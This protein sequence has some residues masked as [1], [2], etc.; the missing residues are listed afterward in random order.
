MTDSAATPSTSLQ[1]RNLGLLVATQSLGGASPP[2]I[3]SLGGLVGQMLSSTP[4]AATLPVSLYQLGLALST[5]PAAWLMQRIGRRRAYLL[6]ALL[7]V[8]SGMVAAWGISRSDFVLFCL[9]TSLAGFYGACVQSYRFA[10]IDTVAEPAQHA[11][12][13]SRV[14]VGGLV[15]AV[16]GP[17]VVIWTRD[18]LPAT[19]FAGS[20]YSQALLALLAL[21][22][23]ALL[24]LP[25]PAPRTAG[26]GARPLAEIARSP[27]FRVA[28][29]AGVVSYGLMAFLMTAAPMAMVGCGHSVGEAALGIQWHVLAMFAPSF[30]TGRLIARFGKRTITG[31]GL[32]LIAASGALALMGLALT[33]FWGALVLLGLG[34]NFG[35]I[36]ATALL[37]ECHQPAE[38]AKVQALNDFLVFGTVALASFGSGQLLYSV[39]W[40]GIN[41]GMLPLV[42]LVLALLAWSG[43]RPRQ[44]VA[45]P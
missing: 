33:H 19:P 30:F 6:G 43:R 1:R 18:L 39:G 28:A 22:L 24:R 17:Q 14:M 2:I 4:S 7:G 42:A 23:I 38:R 41:A 32:L 35:F 26:A 40:A 5:L 36:G 3:I 25:P 13:I 27:Q 34:W 8:L 16:I 44:T 12:A 11:S 29:L 20:F 10:A 45:L 31:L 9:G 37:T 21:P 15:A